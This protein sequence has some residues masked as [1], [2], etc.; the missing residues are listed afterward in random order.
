VAGTVV[1]NLPIGLS[2]ETIFLVG[3]GTFTLADMTNIRIEANSKPLM[4]FRSGTELD[5]FNRFD[6]RAL[7]TNAK[8]LAIDFNRRLLDTREAREFT[9]LGTG[10]P[11]NLNQ[12]LDEAKSRPNPE[13][14]PFPVQTLSLQMDVAATNATSF[15]IYALQSKAAPTGIVKK[16]RKFTYGFASST[17]EISDLPKGDLINR[18]FILE[19]GGTI[20][21]GGNTL[22]DVKIRKDNAIIFDRSKT[23]NDMIQTD[24]LKRTPITAVYAIDT[25]ESGNGAEVITTAGVNDFR[26]IGTLSTTAAGNTNV[27]VEFLGNLDR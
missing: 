12:W 8:I 18:I 24:E 3:A 22:T 26:I 2:Y 23:L 17:F 25:T 4:E 11:P 9:K 20:G 5:G 7:S 21:T 19:P 14:N 1:A 6:R 27:T 16:V 13:Y 10:K 15:T